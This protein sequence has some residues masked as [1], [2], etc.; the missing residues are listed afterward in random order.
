MQRK[1]LVIVRAGDQSLHERWLDGGSRSWD[2]LVSYYGDDPKRYRRDDVQRI[3]GKGLK[4]PALHRLLSEEFTGWRAY[5]HIWLPDDDLDCRAEDI[6]RMFA[7]VAALELKLAQPALAW[8][9]Y[10]SY[11][12]TLRHP[13][14][15]A[16]FTSFIEVMAPCFS[17]GFLERCL[18]TFGEN[19]SGWGLDYLWPRLC[20][21]P[22]ADC[23]VIDVVQVAHTR[24]VGGPSYG[25]LAKQGLN[26]ETELQTLLAKYAIRDRAHLNYGAIDADGQRWSL[27]DEHGDAFIYRLCEGIMDC[28]GT[29][30]RQ[31][32]AMF[33]EHAR[34]RREFLLQQAVA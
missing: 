17:R 31:V 6:D 18:P 26:A 11:L 27:F 32:G 1:N 28:A 10:F 24:P 25:L 23:A 22:A 7:L 13:Y 19:Q 29:D 3:D 12:L 4:F 34:A 20:P 5:D 9:S 2:L 8:R 21:R 14:F 15:S 30:Q 33:A 16:R